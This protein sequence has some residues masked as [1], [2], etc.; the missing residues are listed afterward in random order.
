M[1]VVLVLLIQQATL[2]HITKNLMFKYLIRI[3]RIEIYEILLPFRF[4]HHQKIVR[5]TD[6]EQLKS[7]ID[8]T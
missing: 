5:M 4:V 3:Y 2:L 6:S 8:F 1:L 7:E